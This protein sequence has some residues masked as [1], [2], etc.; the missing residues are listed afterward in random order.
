MDRQKDTNSIGTLLRII[1]LLM[2]LILLLLFILIPYVL[3]GKSSWDWGSFVGGTIGGI[4]TII[5]VCITTKQTR[6][7]QEE[8]RIEKEKYIQEENRRI[9]F[10]NTLIVYYDL[11]FALEDFFE[12]AA[13]FFNDNY[14]ISENKFYEGQFQNTYFDKDWIHTI[15]KI[16]NELSQDE[17]QT[18]YDLYGNISTLLKHATDAKDV[19]TNEKVFIENVILKFYNQSQNAL[20]LKKEVRDLMNTLKKNLDEYGEYRVVNIFINEIEHIRLEK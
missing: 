18:V 3:W 7:I 10:E 11:K 1:L 19:M 4:G 8:N 6:K 13:T 9:L 17:L 20:E 5:A 2:L 16:S 14:K 15:P 12:F